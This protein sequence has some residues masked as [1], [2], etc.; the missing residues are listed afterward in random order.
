MSDKILPRVWM[1]PGAPKH[2][3]GFIQGDVTGT[4]SPSTP[5][6]L[7]P[8]MPVIEHNAILKARREIAGEVA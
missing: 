7:I 8:Y 5:E 2:L 3:S 1:F 4:T 6:N